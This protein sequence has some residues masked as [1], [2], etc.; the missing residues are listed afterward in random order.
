MTRLADQVRSRDGRV[1]GTRCPRCQ[2]VYANRPRGSS[3]RAYDDHTWECLARAAEEA[4]I[5]P[6]ELLSAE[7]AAMSG[8]ATATN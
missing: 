6:L 7:V 5:G 4:G 3:W 8:V 2:V 1:V